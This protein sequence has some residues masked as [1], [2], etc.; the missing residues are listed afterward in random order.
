MQKKFHRSFESLEGIY[1]FAEGIFADQDVQPSVRAPAH[2]VME[3]LFTNMVKHNPGNANDILL[4]VDATTDRITVS[5]TDYD[6]E[7][8]D[9]T[10]ARNVDVDAPLEAR[11]PGGLG[12][13]LIQQ[14]VDTLHY[15]YAN[16]RSTV[17]FTKEAG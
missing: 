9:V 11:A 16:R 3:E 12:L 17:T 15:N 5:L 6:V 13:H 14:M 4:D 10:E 7:A 8:F 1:D 2:F